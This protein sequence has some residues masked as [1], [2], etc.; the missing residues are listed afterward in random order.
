MNIKRQR[1]TKEQKKDLKRKRQSESMRWKYYRRRDAEKIME[2][3][4]AFYAAHPHINERNGRNMYKN[5]G[6][7]ARKRI[8]QERNELKMLSLQAGCNI[9]VRLR[10]DDIVKCMNYFEKLI[11]KRGI[12][13]KSGGKSTL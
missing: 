8:V 4:K 6:E 12:I 9:D 2:A 13:K 11:E 1:F 7:A 10:H 5:G 3:Q